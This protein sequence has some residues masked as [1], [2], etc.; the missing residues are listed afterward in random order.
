MLYLLIVFDRL[1][2]LL[3]SAMSFKL[4]YFRSRWPRALSKKW[5]RL[6]ILRVSDRIP[7][8]VLIHNLDDVFQGPLVGTFAYASPMRIAS[9]PK[10][11]RWWS[12]RGV[13]MFLLTL[14]L[15]L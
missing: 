13:I 7:G 5:K 11:W 14:V 8:V 12:V 1:S 3:K 4:Y 10:A 6:T 15:L 2:W 9:E